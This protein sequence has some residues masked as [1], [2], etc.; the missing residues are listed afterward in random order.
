MTEFGR[1]IGNKLPLAVLGGTLLGAVAMGAEAQA[2]PQDPSAD[3]LY[4]AGRVCA[5]Q[6]FDRDCD[7]VFNQFDLYPNI[8]D[9]RM[10][11]NGNGI[12]DWRDQAFGGRTNTV[13]PPVQPLPAKP[14]AVS[15][16]GVPYANPT[17]PNATNSAELNK[18]LSEYQLR[19]KQIPKLFGP[20]DNS[21]NSYGDTSKNTPPDK[22]DY[23]KGDADGD[24]FNNY[25][26]G[27]LTRNNP[28]MQ[29]EDDWNDRPDA[30]WQKKDD[31]YKD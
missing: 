1:S 3:V 11:L 14:N 26:E 18:I 29:P 7:R 20:T 19:H 13:L 4:M 16:P 24:Y 22:Y 27:S 2:N 9:N 10:D 6:T 30:Y 15:V 8:N 23:F 12:A 25:Q 28:F 5:G 21:G 31:P 17:N